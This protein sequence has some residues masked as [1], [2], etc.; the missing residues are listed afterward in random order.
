[1]LILR[2]LQKK[3]IAVN[4][5]MINHIL[6]HIKGI[7][8]ADMAVKVSVLMMVSIANQFRYLEEKTLFRSSSKKVRRS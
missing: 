1:M 5:I 4:Q 6:N 8:I 2:P 3:Y 7:K